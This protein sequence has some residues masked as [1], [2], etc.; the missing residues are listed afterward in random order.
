MKKNII[1]AKDC[2]AIMKDNFDNSAVVEWCGKQ[3]KIT[4]TISLNDMVE[5]V[6]NVVDNCYTKETATYRPEIR[7]FVIR[8]SVIQHYTNIDMPSETDA[9]Y[10]FLYMTDVY[11][12]VYEYINKE[13]LHVIT[14]AIDWKVNALVSEGIST[15][16]KQMIDL[17]NNVT[18]FTSKFAKLFDGVSQDDMAK[19]VSAMSG[20]DDI[21]ERLI[22]AYS[23]VHSEGAV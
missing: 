21:E 5:F 11:A 20:G 7:D 10:D 17:V 15:A 16:A 14:K 23:K 12:V 18:G 22:R 1:S 13:Q 8:A 3:I 4:K 19:M 9:M 6:R 2:A